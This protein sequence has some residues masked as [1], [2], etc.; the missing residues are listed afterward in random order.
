MSNHLARELFELTGKTAIVTG[1]AGV[2]C[3]Y[4]CRSLALEGVKVA[5]LDIN[6]EGAER[7]ST[8]I[9][10]QG[11]QAMGV[12]CDVCD[13]TSLHAAAQKILDSW[14]RVDILINGAGGN[15]PKATT[16]TEITYFDIP[17]AALELVL[18]LNLLST[19][20]VSQVFGRIM[21]NQNEGVILNMSSMNALRPL[22]KIPAYA[23]AKA[24]ISN[25]TQ[26]LA[27]YMALEYSPEIRVNAI[28]PGFFLTNQNRYI[29]IDHNS[30]ELSERGKAIIA[31]TPMKRFGSLEDLLGVVVWLISPASRFVT[32]TVVPIDGGFS[33]YSGV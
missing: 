32:G 7:L 30:G 16:N 1:G 12:E 23:A 33:A 13:Q 27:V 8:E 11:G 21:A 14:K 9:V 22:T 20:L 25:F 26:W 24:G 3:S 6:G 29:L 18:D 31:H 5:V 10:Q 15:N 19:M 2:I 17:K 4:L 28:A